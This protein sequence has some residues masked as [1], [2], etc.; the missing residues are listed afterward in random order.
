M[1]CPKICTLLQIFY[2]KLIFFETKDTMILLILVEYYTIKTDI[3]R[4]NL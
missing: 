1:Y 4:Y 2:E 3:I